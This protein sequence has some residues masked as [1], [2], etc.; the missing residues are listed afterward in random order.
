MNKKIIWILLLV[1]IFIFLAF[2]IYRQGMF[3]KEILKLEIFGPEV[4]K[5]GEEI[6]YTVQY[7]NNGNFVLQKPELIFELPE[8]SLTEDER[9]ILRES[10]GDIYPGQ[11][12]SVKFKGRLLGKDDDLKTA[13]AIL[14]YTPKNIT[15]KYES[16]T[17]F[18]TKIDAG[19]INLSFDLPTK[20]EQ[21]KS[22]TYSINYFSNIDYPL[23][24]LSIKIDPSQGFEIISSDPKSLDNQE[25]KLPTLVKTQGGRIIINGK[26]LAGSD[27]SISLKAILGIWQEGKFVVIKET[28]ANLQII[29]PMI[30][31][32]Q[33]INGSSNYIASPG[34]T[35][36]YRVF[37]TNIGSTA[38]EN[39]FMAV[40]LDGQALDMS[41]L[42]VESNG[43]IRVT[44]NMIVWDSSSLSY[45]S[46][47]MP[48]QEGSVGFSIKI[49]DD[50]APVSAENS[51]IT[52]EVSVSQTNQKFTI[53]VNSGLSVSQSAYY[54]STDISNTGPIPPEISKPTTYTVNWEIRNY[55]SDK[56]N[57]KVKAFLPENIFLTGRIMPENELSKF[58]YDSKSR[59]IVWSVGDILAGTGVNGD[60]VA[61]AFQISL[62]PNEA[63]K[64]KTAP[65]IGR[66]IISGENQFT[67]TVITSTDSAIDTTL[68]DDISSSGGGVVK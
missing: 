11:Q 22:L 26:I 49:K 51:V 58:A 65:L 61:L 45:L 3:S 10:L 43:Q 64:G 18:I 53:K 37:F 34:E 60:P 7:K 20:V 40:K 12:D 4:A 47:L 31:I 56:K 24:K 19:N 1:V 42:E 54:K 59:E 6:E 66:A 39:L 13:K 52:N 15:A 32:N 21:G 36:R 29:N 14:I 62:T 23:E 35:L 5:I 33:Q 16:K 50:W 9:V 41:S 27:Q 17:S 46:R 8:N 30:S 38:F 57:V 55:L 48:Q 68:P 67:G 63:Q 28:D 25:W 44:D 2:S